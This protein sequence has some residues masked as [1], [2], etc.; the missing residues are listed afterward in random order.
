[1]ALRRRNNAWA[2]MFVLLMLSQL[3]YAQS[4]DAEKKF[5]WNA[6]VYGLGLKPLNSNLLSQN[7]LQ[8][9][10]RLNLFYSPN[11]NHQFSVQFRNLGMMGA[12]LKPDP[13]V[14]ASGLDAD[15]GAMDLNFNII[16]NKDLVFNI[17]I[18]RLYYQ[19][20]KDKVE[21]T[22]GRQRINWGRTLVWN[23]ND[24]FNASSFLEFNYEE[25]PGA[26]A[27]R[28]VYYSSG[29]S[30]Y[31]LAVKLDSGQRVTAAAKYGF[32]YKYTD[33]QVL[34]G[35]FNDDLV[36][37]FGWAGNIKQ[38]GFKGEFTLFVPTSDTLLDTK[39]VGTISADYSFNNG[40]YVLGQVLYSPLDDNAIFNPFSVAGGNL[41]ARNLSFA[42]W[43]IVVQGSYSF[44]PL[45]SATLALMSFPD[46]ESVL[47]F[48]SFNYSLANNLD[49]NLTFQSY[50]S[51]ADLQAANSFAL[52]VL[53][54]GLK[55]FF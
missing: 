45:F 49:M 46:Q 16:K 22:V 50:H 18:D 34:A 44:N 53:Y 39:L 7:S 4:D 8:V 33:I 17:N 42:E 24:I 55:Y 29:N 21:F 47:I 48:P 36:A 32:N 13:D 9:Y 23:P 31:D 38:V 43:N 51:Y 35:V 10:N 20:S 26:D 2:C 25:M 54:L 37:G 15:M 5:T 40:L 6:Y 12:W 41:N 52:Q 3:L 19:Y 1:M 30:S 11:A 28:L 27:A 14:L